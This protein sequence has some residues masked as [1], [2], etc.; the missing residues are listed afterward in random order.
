VT[1][2][3]ISAGVTTIPEIKRYILDKEK[4]EKDTY[5]FLKEKK[6]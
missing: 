3:W 4:K 1:A 2:A 5:I 6:E